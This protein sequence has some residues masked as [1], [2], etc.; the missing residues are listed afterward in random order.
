[1]IVDQNYSG[2]SS[3]QYNFRL[4][5]LTIK[6]FQRML[7][8]GNS[9]FVLKNIFLRLECRTFFFYITTARSVTA[10]VQVRYFYI[11]LHYLQ[12]NLYKLFT[13]IIIH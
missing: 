11:K 5:I 1:M 3:I 2:H 12:K 10:P 7:I 9:F 13:K 4:N 6:K 8:S